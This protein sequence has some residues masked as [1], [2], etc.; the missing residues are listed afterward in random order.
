MAA[1][2]ALTPDL[3]L[4]A[5]YKIQNPIRLCPTVPVLSHLPSGLMAQSP[6]MNDYRGSNLSHKPR[7]P[8]FSNFLSGTGCPDL[9]FAQPR[10]GSSRGDFLP[11]NHETLNRP[12]ATQSTAWP[13]PDRLPPPLPDFGPRA[14]ERHVEQSQ[15]QFWPYSSSAASDRTPAAVGVCPPGPPLDRVHGRTN[16]REELVPGKGPCYLYDDGTSSQ[17]TGDGDAVNPKWGT[18]KAGKPRKRL[19]QACNT[20]REK[21]IKCDPSVPKCAQCKKFGRECKFDSG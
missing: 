17:K 9:N 6:P 5:S 1:S 3:R 13:T 7:L 14:H 12:A 8:S 11:V 2:V 10:P 19:G 16:V 4:E 20:C 15:A 18:T 21:K